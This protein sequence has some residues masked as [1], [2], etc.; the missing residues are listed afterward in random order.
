MAFDIQIDRAAIEA[1]FDEQHLIEALD[2][3]GDGEEDPGLFESLA[4]QAVKEV[5]GRAELVAL[6]HPAPP[7]AFLERAAVACLCAMLFRRRGVGGEQNPFAER[8]KAAFGMLD[9]LAAGEITARTT[10]PRIL[11]AGTDEEP[12][13]LDFPVPSPTPTEAAWG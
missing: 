8:E 10:A 2:D 13:F 1:E 12:V 4:A 11:V 9:K 7:A 5:Q 3:D 6:A